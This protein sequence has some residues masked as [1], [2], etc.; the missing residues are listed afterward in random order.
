MSKEWARSLAYESLVHG[1]CN[2]SGEIIVL[3]FL[4]E[5]ETMKLVDNA[6]SLTCIVGIPGLIYSFMYILT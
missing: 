2:F 1:D 5:F 3:T 6:D 4:P